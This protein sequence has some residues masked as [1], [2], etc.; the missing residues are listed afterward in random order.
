[1]VIR[2]YRGFGSHREI[3]LFGR[4]LRQSEVGGRFNRG[5]LLVD[6]IALWRRMWRRGVRHA[7]V[8]V[9]FGGARQRSKTDRFGFF[10]IR[11]PILPPDGPD[12][13]WH[14]AVLEVS[15]PN[16]EPVRAETDVLVAPR[17]AEYVVISDIDDTV[18]Y[19]GV[20]QK[21]KMLWHL[22]FAKAGSRVAFPGV[23]EFY[24]ALHRGASGEQRNPLLYVSRGPWSIYGAL[25]AFFHLHDIPIGPVLYLRYWGM[26]VDHPLPRKAKDHKLAIIRHMLEVYGN[27]AF[28]LIGDSGQKDPEIYSRIV[29]EYPGRIRAIY[30]REVGP[31]LERRHAIA[32]MAREA[33][34][35]GTEFLLAADSHTM[36]VHAARQGLIDEEAVAE[37]LT[38]CRARALS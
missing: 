26:T 36:A 9:S 28:V 10:F 17:S 33:A 14:R 23:G 27:M 6:L 13:L 20:A 7:V 38:E 8:E 19:T 25:E 35:S 5:D 1:M 30:I 21:I 3:C 22:F 4:V 31:A 24:R 18:V 32:T 34:P 2:T 29:R 16:G 11:L 12:R 15:P 37:V